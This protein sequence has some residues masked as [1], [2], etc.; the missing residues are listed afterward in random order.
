VLYLK[1]DGLLKDI[2]DLLHSGWPHHDDNRPDRSLPLVLAM[3]FVFALVVA[4]VVW[5]AFSIW[6]L[7]WRLAVGLS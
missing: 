2:G 4:L 7:A 1:E 3:G 5:L 6:R